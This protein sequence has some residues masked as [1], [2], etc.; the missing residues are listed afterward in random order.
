MENTFLNYAL[1]YASAGF[2]VFPLLQGDKKPLPRSSGYKE[3]T[4][5]TEKSENGGKITQ[6]TI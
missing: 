2:R 3:A 1:L 6:N 5:D 4:T